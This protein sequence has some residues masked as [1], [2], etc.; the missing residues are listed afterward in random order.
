MKKTVK[1]DHFKHYFYPC[2]VQTRTACTYFI[3]RRVNL[4]QN[5]YDSALYMLRGG[6]AVRLTAGDDVSSYALVGDDIF[7]PALRHKQDKAAAEAGRP[8]TVFYRLPPRGEAAE[9]FRLDMQVQD[10]FFL[11][12]SRFVFTAWYDPAVDQALRDAQGQWDQALDERKRDADYTVLDELPFWMN[13]EGV[14]NKKRTR[15]YFYNAG[16]IVPLTDEQTAV[17]DVVLAPDNGSVIFSAY[18]FDHV[19][20]YQN[21]LMRV[22]LATRQL[23]DISPVPDATYGL[24]AYADDDTLVLFINE[25]RQYGMNENPRICRYHLPSNALTTLY[26]GGEFCAGNAVG[27]DIRQGGPALPQMWVRDGHYY[28]VSTLG[29]HSHLVKGSLAGGS[30]APLGAARGVVCEAYAVPDGFLTVSLHGNAGCEI[31]RVTLDGAQKR[32]SN[33]NRWILSTYD[34]VIPRE[35]SFLNENGQPIYGW[36]LPPAKLEPAR[37]YPAIL[38]IHGGPKTAY[39][40]N[41]FHEM[42][43]WAAQGYAVL[44]CN[45]TGSEGRGDA[46]ADIRGAYGSVDYRDIM[47]F[48]D[49]AL[50]TFPFID[51]QRLGVTGGSY[52]GF[53]TNWIVG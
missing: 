1:I 23:R 3:G 31:Y 17:E 35:I 20:R 44:F 24:R 10:F 22:D 30:P 6:D 52:G 5:R 32:L 39:G 2:N 48:V 15:L 19:M 27:S 43:Y 46:F 53:M 34:A 45:P 49:K 50:Q 14:T 38:N 12:D 7:F 16:N 25:G 51:A 26:D 9:A 36:V 11:D 33:F 13:G 42:Q 47:A 29:H 8:L 37:K 40:P 18:T 28:F 41:F 4:E 21:R